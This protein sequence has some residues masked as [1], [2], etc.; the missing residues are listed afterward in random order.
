MVFF[1]IFFIIDFLVCD[2]EKYMCE[3]I[4]MGICEGLEM[5]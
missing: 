3:I 1:K 4:F 2:I 5:C